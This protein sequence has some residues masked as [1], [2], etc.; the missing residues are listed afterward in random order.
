MGEYK[1]GFHPLYAIGILYVLLTYAYLVAFV[2]LLPDEEYYETHER[3]GSVLG[4]YF[5]PSNLPLLMLL[6][7]LVLFFVCLF[8]A[9]KWKNADRNYF[10]NTS[11][12]IKY[13]LIP[14]YIAGG[15]LILIL[16][17][18]IF[19]P[20]IIMIFVSPPLIAILSVM[21]WLS[22]AG[23]LPVTLGYFVKAHRAKDNGKF[24]TVLCSVA[25]F[26]FTTDVISVMFIA[27]KRNRFRKLTVVMLVIFA[28]A[29]IAMFILLTLLMICIVSWILEAK[30]G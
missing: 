13:C 28:L 7:P 26:F 3:T 4:D 18:L 22:V 2:K 16:A 9:I 19:T 8:A 15:L 6:V 1:K 10:L 17:L 23:A 25:Q 20:V 14:F 29:V 24:L 21:G 27:I 5:G 11:I 12:L 30:A